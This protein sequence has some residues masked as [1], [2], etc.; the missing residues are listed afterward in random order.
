MRGSAEGQQKL[1]DGGNA[2]VHLWLIP[3][4]QSADGL[5]MTTMVCHRL[6]RP[7][8]VGLIVFLFI[9]P[10]ASESGLALAPT[11][12]SNVAEVR[13]T[14]FTMDRNNRGVEQLQKSD[15]A[16]VDNGLVIRDFRSFSRSQATELELL[17][18]VDSSE[19][20]QPR[21][22]RE[23]AEVLRLVS[24][25][26]FIPGD[27]IS[28]VAFGGG[29]PK[30]ICS[31][32]CRSPA[33]GRLAATAAGG[34]TAL[35]DAVRFGASSLAEHG[36]PASRRVVIL[37]SD[38]EDTFSRSAADDAIEAALRAEAQIYAVD[39]GG[40]RASSHGTEVLERMAESTGGRYF[41]AR[42]GAVPVLAAALEDLRAGYIVTYGLADRQPGFHSVRIFPTRNLNLQFRCRQGYHYENQVR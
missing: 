25:T 31:G 19:S 28:I 7:T 22:R 14:F 39:L 36:D 5:L 34:P 8:A 2:R 16:V 4:V 35:Y 13:L 21:F 32:D 37:F 20:V 9:S 15:F 30:L 33:V 10:G 18:L 6:L 41:D 29:E 17:L 42:E 40:P 24:E 11:Y 3:L 12:R 1:S 27:H 38:G 26:N 23:I